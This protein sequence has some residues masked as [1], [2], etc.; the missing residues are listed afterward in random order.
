VKWDEHLKVIDEAIK[1]LGSV[2]W[3]LYRNEVE[4]NYTI[5]PVT[6]RFLREIKNVS[7]RLGWNLPLGDLQL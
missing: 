6:N 1:N 4:K 2:N 3:E 5:K 7:D